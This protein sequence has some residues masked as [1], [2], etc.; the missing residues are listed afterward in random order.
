MIPGQS[1]HQPPGFPEAWCGLWK[2]G[3]GKLLYLKRITGRQLMASISPGH[4][5]PFFPLPEVRYGQS[6]R[7]PALYQ[8]DHHGLLFLR[9]EAGEGEWGPF[10][11]IEFIY[12]EGDRLRPAEPFD[13][14]S[15]VIARPRVTEG[16]NPA[17][18]EN[19]ISWAHPLSNYWKADEEEARY[20]AW[21][22]GINSSE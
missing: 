21:L 22:A 19:D 18:G 1:S 7:L 17:H 14:A 20:L 2:D 6:H 12:G 13:P 11:E 3:Y 15:G 4:G 8:H 16:L 5:Q 9:I 10:Y